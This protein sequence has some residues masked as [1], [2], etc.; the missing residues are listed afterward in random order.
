V[1]LSVDVPR[2]CPDDIV[3]V[4]PDDGDAKQFMARNN[5]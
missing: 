3:F 1:V 4:N 2:R 5:L